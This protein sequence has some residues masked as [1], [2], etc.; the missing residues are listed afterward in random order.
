MAVWMLVFAAGRT[1]DLGALEAEFAAVL[2]HQTDLT[3]VSSRWQRASG[4]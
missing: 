3:R 2:V 4:V 1:T